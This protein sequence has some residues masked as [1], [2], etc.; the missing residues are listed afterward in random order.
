MAKINI[1]SVFEASKV[2]RTE[3]GK[4]LAELVNTVAEIT[5]QVVPALQGKLTFKDNFAADVKE[6]EVEADQAQVVSTRQ[7][8]VGVIP[9]RVLS[10]THQ[11]DSFGWW[12]DEKSQLTVKAGFTGSPS[13]KLTISL[14]VLY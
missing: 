13:Q 11:L 2:M 14:I 12:L 3:A 4:Q 10:L 7:T 1:S 9:I 5:K 6:I 8:P